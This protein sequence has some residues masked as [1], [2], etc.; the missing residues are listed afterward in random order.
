MEVSKRI[1]ILQ[2][3]CNCSSI[4]NN[5]TA[6]RI[7]K[8][9]GKNFPIVQLVVKRNGNDVYFYNGPV[10][11]KPSI[12]ARQGIIGE[13]NY[14]NFPVVGFLIS[15]DDYVNDL[16]IEARNHA[17]SAVK[18]GPFLY[19][20][21][22]FGNAKT[23]EY[24]TFDRRIFEK[25]A[26][27]YNCVLFYIY[28]GPNLQPTNDPICV[29]YAADF[30]LFMFKKIAQG[31][32]QAY[33]IANL[34]NKNV[35]DHLRISRVFPGSTPRQRAIR[36]KRKPNIRSAGLVARSEKL[37]SPTRRK[38]RLN[39]PMNVNKPKSEPKSMNVD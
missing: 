10:A 20:F 39:D 15:V 26:Q 19:C 1:R 31:I 6:N 2:P 38:D 24:K 9:S 13:Q 29:T 18:V 32:N 33:Y 3:D 37:S 5:A 28:D 25:I 4:V 7:K 27:R 22:T 23:E 30:I 34:T 17:V 35:L 12:I 16:S 8:Q 21:N 14:L 11:W 36:L